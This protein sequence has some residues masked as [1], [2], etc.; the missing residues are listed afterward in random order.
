MDVAA[1][2]YL[3]KNKASRSFR[4]ALRE[5]IIKGKFLALGIGL[6]F[7]ATYSAFLVRT[8]YND[9]QWWVAHGKALA[10]ENATLSRAF[11]IR[12]H[13]MVRTDPVFDNTRALLSAFDTYRHA[14]NGKPCEVMVTAPTT[15]SSPIVGMIF[16][17]SRPV[18]DCSTVG[19]MNSDSD[20]DIERRAMDGMVPYKIVFHAER[21]NKAADRLFYSLASLVQMQRSYDMPSAAD[22]AHYGV[23][24]PSQEDFVWLQFGTNVRWNSELR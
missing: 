6:F 2:W 23:R 1:T 7:L 4:K 3:N 14:Q 20:P 8:V 12:K 11:E 19:L 21:G 22:Q 13:S 10:D 16:D 17:L 15:D 5:P 18:S 9:H 24:N